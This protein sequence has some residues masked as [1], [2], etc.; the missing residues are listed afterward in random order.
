MRIKLGIVGIGK[1]ARAE[2]LPVLAESKDFDL[3]AAASRN[4]TVDG[5]RNFQSLAQMLAEAPEIEAVSLCAPP[6]ARTADARAAL[7]AGKHVMLEKPPGAT[8]SE[9][10]DLIARAKDA[11]VTLFATWHS[12]FAAGVAPAR[13]WL[14]ERRIISVSIIWK[15]DVRVWHPGQDWIFDAG[16]FGVFDPGINALSIVTHILPQSF[17]LQRAR[18]DVPANK[19]APIAAELHFATTDGAPIHAVFD[20][21]QTG[22]QSW[23]IIVETES[24]RL[25]LNRGGA[26]ASV[27]GKS[28]VHSIEADTLHGEYAGLY[29]AFADL[30]ARK[31]SDADI[32][33]FVHVADA[34][35]LGSRENVAPF[36]F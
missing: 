29:R 10:T 26:D 21:L 34:F 2:H 25:E 31:S 15:E 12:R 9:V 18:L 3:I 5:L 30:I 36:A 17:A 22:P 1:I 20:F 33:P 6:M 7:A 28:I 16:G 23:D 8:I 24:G 4:A 35:T 19:Q 27:D 13:A 14:A 32:A 11:G